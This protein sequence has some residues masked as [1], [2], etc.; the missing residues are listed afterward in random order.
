MEVAV[1]PRT[2]GSRRTVRAATSPSALL[3][4]RTARSSRSADAS[5]ACRLRSIGAARRASRCRF[6]S[7][8]SINACRS[9]QR[10]SICPGAS[11]DVTRR[12]PGA[13]ISSAWRAGAVLPASPCSQVATRSTRRADLWRRG[14]HDRV[15]DRRAFFAAP[16]IATGCSRRSASSRPY[17][18]TALD[19][20]ALRQAHPG[21]PRSVSGAA[22]YARQGREWLDRLAAEHMNLRAAPT[23]S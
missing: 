6:C 22:S 16:T 21:M 20:D 2:G 5:T 13:T 1:D 18:S 19:A 10:L 12:S 17:G 15:R 23:A 3:R 14:G 11:A 4:R 8:G 9:S 7:N